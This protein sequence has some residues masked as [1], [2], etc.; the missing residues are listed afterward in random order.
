MTSRKNSPVPTA[1]NVIKRPTI[2]DVARQS[3]VSKATASKALS[4]P[5]ERCPVSKTTRE[6]VLQVAGQMGYRPNWRAKAL[7]DGRSHTIGLLYQG[8]YP[9]Y[10]NGVYG[11]MIQS[12]ALTLQSQGFHLL[13]V[14]IEGDGSWEHMLLDRRLDGCVVADWIPDAVAQILA[15]AQMPV[16]LLNLQ[17]TLPYPTVV[18]DDHNGAMLLTR[19]LQQLGHRHIVFYEQPGEGTHFSRAARRAG[20]QQA[21][22][23]AGLRKSAR[24]VQIAPAQF[25]GQLQK[26]LRKA[27]TSRPTAIITYADSDAMELLHALW[28]HA[29]RVPADVS[30]ATFNDVHP[31]HLLTPPV[32]AVHIPAEEI[33]RQGAEI[34]LRQIFDATPPDVPSLVLPETLTLRA[35]TA[36]PN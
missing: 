12:F 29:I 14:P 17:S 35:S 16:V 2:N 15:S 31:L 4:L 11:A 32:T 34:L 7:A 5:P 36:P 6:H 30:L 24:E 10:L 28:Q 13:F 25:A 22:R 33:G 26:T 19:H 27:T 18:P 9:W 3:G 21:M 8:P 1:N 20:F 23:E